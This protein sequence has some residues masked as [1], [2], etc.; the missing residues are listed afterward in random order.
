MKLYLISQNENRGFNT[1]DSM[2]V[3][4]E[5]EESAKQILPSPSFSWDDKSDLDSLGWASSPDNVNVEYIG[6]ASDHLK[7]GVVC[8]SFNEG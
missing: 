3:C 5:S 8:S 2:V 4:A 1:F 6:E 7:V